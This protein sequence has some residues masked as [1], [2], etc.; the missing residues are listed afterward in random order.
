MRTFT[1]L[2]ENQDNQLNLLQFLTALVILIKADADTRL[3]FFYMVHLIEIPDL[4]VDE[5]PD[6]MEEATEATEFF[7]GS[8]PSLYSFCSTEVPQET[9][10][11]TLVPL[12]LSCIGSRVSSLEP[13]NRPSL[14]PPSP[15]ITC[16]S[17]GASLLPK[18][19]QPSLIRMWKT[20]YDVFAD[21]DEKQQIHHS[22]AIVGT[23]ILRL[24]ELAQQH[25]EATRKKDTQS[26]EDNDNSCSSNS[27][28]FEEIER[29]SDSTAWSITY[30]H[31]KA[32][33]YKEQRLVDLF[34][35]KVDVSSLLEKLRDTKNGRAM[36]IVASNS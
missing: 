27:E 14:C 20:F 11:K 2:D 26:K 23:E 15:K 29:P 25:E 28:S 19:D 33:L 10:S 4:D 5:S 3:K 36:S 12:F 34:E 21:S 22:I 32:T 18:M 31:V 30:E 35:T 9:S 16:E 7:Q 17:P 24:A 1:F 8:P 6:D 13:S